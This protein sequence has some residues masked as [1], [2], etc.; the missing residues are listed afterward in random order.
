MLWF[1]R[2]GLLYA[3]FTLLVTPA[4]AAPS[5]DAKGHFIKRAPAAPAKVVRC[6]DAKGKLA[7]CGTAGAAV[8]PLGKSGKRGG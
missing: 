1:V 5:H 8:Q 7:K 6:K 4:I 2:C 3:S